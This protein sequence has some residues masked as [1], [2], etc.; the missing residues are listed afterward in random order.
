MKTIEER[1]PALLPANL[2]MVLPAWNDPAA[3]D[4]WAAA[5]MKP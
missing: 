3:W 2:P 4:A 1:F 5:N